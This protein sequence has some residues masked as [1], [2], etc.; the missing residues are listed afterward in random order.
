MQHSLTSNCICTSLF[1][2]TTFRRDRDS[3]ETMQPVL[4]AYDK[5]ICIMQRC[6]G[7]RRMAVGEEDGGNEASSWLDDTFCVTNVFIEFLVAHRSWVSKF[8][9]STLLFLLV[10]P[11][12]NYSQLY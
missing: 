2:F 4:F 10:S 8:T 6:Q 9:M 5:H 3:I 1:V 7:K 12:M 11:V